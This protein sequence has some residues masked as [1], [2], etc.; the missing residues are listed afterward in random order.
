MTI[1]V[2]GVSGQV[3][4]AVAR[5]LSG[6]VR[7]SRSG[8]GADVALD[9]ADASAIVR[10]LRAVKPTVVINPAA[11][12]LV[13]RAEDEPEAAARINTTA[14]AVLAEELAKTGGALV[15]FSTD[16]VYSDAG[17]QPLDESTPIAPIN[18]YGRT[19]AEGD[20]LVAEL[21]PRHVVLRTSWVYAAM[22]TNFVRTMLRLGAEREELRVVADQHGAPTSAEFLAEVVARVLER[23]VPG[24]YHATC[25]G[26][27]T[28]HGFAE[29]IF[30]QAR[31]L[32]APLKV[33]RVL[34]IGSGEFPTRAKRPTNSRLS[35]DKLVSTFGLPQVAWAD[36]LAPVL[37][38]L[39]CSPR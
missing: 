26:E 1:L 5:R 32:G 13:D 16:Y 25:G 12:T 4:H 38:S 29:E 21:L 28:W 6:V 35:C 19:K 24:V 10:V 8:E 37:R 20:R 18:T 36:A 3:G 27:T 34:P 11:W 14:P 15:H 30:R 17:D 2:T 39:V 31:A 22:G 7:A 9:L 23:E 33:A